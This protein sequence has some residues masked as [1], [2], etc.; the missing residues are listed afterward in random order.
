M[1]FDPMPQILE[2]IK[3]KDKDIINQSK[4][5]NAIKKSK[6]NNGKTRKNFS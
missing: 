4:C 3:V 5:K 2:N 6:S 1:L